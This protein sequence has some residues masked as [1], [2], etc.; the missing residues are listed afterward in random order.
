M[1]DTT[2]RKIVVQTKTSKGHPPQGRDF[3]NVLRTTYHF[4]DCRYADGSGYPVD[5]AEAFEQFN[6]AA[7]TY[8]GRYTKACKVCGASDALTAYPDCGD[9]YD[10]TFNLED[11][12]TIASALEAAI[13]A[14]VFKS[15][16]AKDVRAW[17][18]V[19]RPL[20]P[21]SHALR[22]YKEVWA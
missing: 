10:T 18:E 22:L 5:E 3:N 14:N 13:E 6:R 21:N 1:T 4:D 8:S 2:T 17:A 9:R 15:E 11:T 7:C 19:L 16:R 20:Q 12:D